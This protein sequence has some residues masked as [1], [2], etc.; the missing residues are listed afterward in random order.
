MEQGY[1]LYGQ[2]FMI[3]LI[4]R[5][6]SSSSSTDKKALGKKRCLLDIQQTCNFL[7]K[8]NI[9]FYICIQETLDKKK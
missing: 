9:V 1:T 7:N 3:P 2:Q 6:N 8:N 5:E 4:L